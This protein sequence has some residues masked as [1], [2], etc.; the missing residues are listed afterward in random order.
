MDTLLDFMLAR[1][2]EFQLVYSR[3]LESISNHSLRPL[4]NVPLQSILAFVGTCLLVPSLT[5]CSGRSRRVI[6]QTLDTAVAIVLIVLLLAMI[7][8]LPIGKKRAWFLEKAPASM[9]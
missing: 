1:A 8:G 5:L 6:F 7:L 4:Q 3:A 2:L 9:H